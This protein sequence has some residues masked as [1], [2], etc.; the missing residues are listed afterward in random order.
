[1][2]R[3]KQ[4][5]LYSSFASLA[6]VVSAVLTFPYASLGRRLE[7][8]T[9][10]ALPGST[11]VIGEIGPALPVG[12][13]LARVT[14]HRG[15]GVENRVEIDRLRLKPAFLSLLKL[16]PGMN[17]DLRAFS[18]LAK[19][20]VGMGKAG[21]SFEL[22]L[23]DLNLQEATFLKGLA[24]L[25]LKGELSGQIQLEVS[26]AGELQNGLIQAHFADARL[27]SG[28]VMGFSLPA[29]DLGSPEIHI[30]ISEGKATLERLGIDS[31]DGSLQITGDI[32]LKRQLATSPIKGK[33]SVKLEDA[34]LDKNPSI[35]SLMTF[36]GNLKQ[37]DGSIE[38]E[39]DG[40]LARSVRLPRLGIR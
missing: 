20:Q 12:L 9:A 16:K 22:S 4:F 30:P 18:G 40:P 6:L 29:L 11:L 7:A 31:P 3:K 1:M 37:P 14:L 17:F 27:D 15:T 8:E 38:L 32:M 13:R 34:F 28:K 19:G 2:S 26:P 24:D 39:L 25:S 5:L 35:K 21:S 23:K 36:A 33:I 10:K